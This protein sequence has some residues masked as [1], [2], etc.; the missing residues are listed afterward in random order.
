MTTDTNV[1]GC[2]VV[3]GALPFYINF[4][5]CLHMPG[6]ILGTVYALLQ[7]YLKSG[8][9]DKIQLYLNLIPS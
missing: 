8:L 7:Q 1:L 9:P 4:T 3:R 5:T 2:D 6:T